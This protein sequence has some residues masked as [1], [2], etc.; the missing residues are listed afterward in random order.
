MRDWIDLSEGK[1]NSAE[2]IK[3]PNDLGDISGK[4]IFLCG[5]I[6]MGKAIDWQTQVEAGLQDEAVTILNPRRDD[7]DSSWDQSIDNP[8]FKEQVDWELDGMQIADII[9]F[10]FDPN[11]KAPITLLEL[12]LNAKDKYDDIIVY[13]PEG[14]WRK[15][16]VDI[17]CERYSIKTVS[18]IV[19]LIAEAKKKIADIA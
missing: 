17:V 14:Y 11:G 2:V 10:Y 7:W 12:G 18:N 15:G 8:Q 19:E 4:T 16:N 1:Q 6:D 3:A 5:S 9:L 13:C